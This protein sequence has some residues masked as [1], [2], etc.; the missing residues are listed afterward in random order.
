MTDIDVTNILIVEDFYDEEEMDT[1]KIEIGVPKFIV[2]DS[3]N[4]GYWVN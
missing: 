3:T 2:T 1:V 4:M